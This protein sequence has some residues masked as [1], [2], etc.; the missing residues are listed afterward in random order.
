MRRTWIDLNSD[1]GESFG[2]FVLGRPEEV[3]KR[4]SHA[5]IACGFH[6]G[7]P[8]WMRRTVEWAKQYGV[9]IGAHPGF[10]DL[11]GFGRRLMNITLQEATNYV[12]YQ[13]GALKAFCAMHGLKLRAGKPHGAFYS[14]SILS[15]DNARAV[16]EGF[17]AI[18][19]DLTLYLPALPQFPLIATA[20]KIGF[21]V[22]KEFYPGLSYDDKGAIT[23]KRTY[24]TESVEEIVELVLRF[25]ID[26]KTTTT[27]GTVID[28]EG[29]SV[30]VHG[31]VVNAPE[32]LDGV[33]AALRQEGIEVRSAIYTRQEEQLPLRRRANA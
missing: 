26:G 28:V 17:Q 19:P 15:G 22:V 21:R 30:C 14:W 1:M 23:V 18:D 29:D 3:M 7:D 25:A 11:M 31:D 16:L 32:V 12:V 13:A 8:T 33:H 2:N 4:I 9:T 10:P 6:A 27:T 5:N 24:G 20:E